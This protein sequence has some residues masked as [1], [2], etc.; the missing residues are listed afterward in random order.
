MGL[1]GSKWEER[2]IQR[3]VAVAD[4]TCESGGK[5]KYLKVSR[6]P[7]ARSSDTD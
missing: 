4:N 6:Q 5:F 2:E 7:T 1:G 3:A